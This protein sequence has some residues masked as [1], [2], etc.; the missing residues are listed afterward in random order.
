MEDRTNY[1]PQQ[2]YATKNNKNNNFVGEYDMFYVFFALMWGKYILHDI[3]NFLTKLDNCQRF[4][5]VDK[6]FHSG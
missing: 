1:L 5:T 2:P 3:E 4:L 6:M